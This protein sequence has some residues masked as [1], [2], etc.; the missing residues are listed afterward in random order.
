MYATVRS[1]RR[2]EEA[3]D[4]CIW[5]SPEARKRVAVILLDLADTESIKGFA[6]QLLAPHE[7]GGSNGRL[8]IL[9]NNAGVSLQQYA[10]TKQGLEIHVGINLVGTATLTY[11]LLPLLARTGAQA[12]YLESGSSARIVNLASAA[13]AMAPAHMIRD[14][15]RTLAPAPRWWDL[16][17]TWRRYGASKLG[18]FAWTADL[19][20]S[21]RHAGLNVTVLAVHPGTVR[22]NFEASPHVGWAISLLMSFMSRF[23]ITVEEGARS[24]L[25]AA[26]SPAVDQLRWKGDETALKD[27]GVPVP[28]TDKSLS[29]LASD[30]EEQAEVDE[31]VQAALENAGVSPEW[32]VERARQEAN[33]A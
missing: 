32:Y 31:F 30:P 13:A 20:R 11:L 26:T 18:V 14:Y 12:R 6:A 15:E 17:S 4:A 29:G 10:Q 2:G 5:S 1:V 24:P 22:T 27:L 33:V 9:I 7:Q 16:F 23:W 21:L 19:S 28:L 8:D 25:C 3:F